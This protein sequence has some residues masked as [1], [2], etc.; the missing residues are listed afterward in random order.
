ML[1]YN[2]KETTDASQAQTIGSKC[3]W[4][5]FDHYQWTTAL[6]SRFWAYSQL[7]FFRLCTVADQIIHQKPKKQHSRHLGLNW[8]RFL[9]ELSLEIKLLKM[10]LRIH[11]C[12][13]TF[14]IHSNWR[15]N[16]SK[17]C[18]CLLAP[19]TNSLSAWAWDGSVLWLYSKGPA[20]TSVFEWLW[21]WPQWE[22]C[23][24]Q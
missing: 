10:K 12:S 21:L 15:S 19:E 5:C 8:F 14:L 13:Q 11:K 20:L 6:S 24:E 4:A 17:I 2:Q 9:F 16:L 23:R 1:Q 18:L 22:L 7:Q 3:C